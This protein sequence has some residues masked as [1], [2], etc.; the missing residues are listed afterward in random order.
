MK[1][2][3]E[4]KFLVNGDSWRVAAEAGLA[5]RQGYITSGAQG[6]TVRVRLM[7][8]RGFLTVKG[9]VQGISRPEMEYE[10]PAADAEYMLS[11]FCGTRLVSKIRYIVKSNDLRWEVDEFSGANQGLVMAEIELEREDQPFE[12]PSWLGEEVSFDPRYTNA[13]LAR[14]PFTAW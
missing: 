8:P 2:E 4:R 11:A 6:A 12:R 13:M 14:N 7:G 3:I 9:P 5:C 1:H 10:I